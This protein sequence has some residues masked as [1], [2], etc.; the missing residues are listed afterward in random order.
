MFLH[1]FA[2]TRCNFYFYRYQTPLKDLL[3]PNFKTSKACSSS[4]INK[5]SITTMKPT[6]IN[7]NP[8]NTDPSNGSELLK[9]CFSQIGNDVQLHTV[10]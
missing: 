10:K 1:Y 8:S 9:Y 3:L 5:D 7:R 2:W 6:R 4:L